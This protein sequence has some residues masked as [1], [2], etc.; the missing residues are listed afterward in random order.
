MKYIYLI[1]LATILLGCSGMED[2][3]YKLQR[4]RNQKGE[5][6]YRSNQHHLATNPVPI[7]RIRGRYPWEK[8]LVGAHPKITKEFFRCKGNGLNASRIITEAGKEPVRLSDC[9]GIDKHSLY[10]RGGDEFIYPILLDLLNYVQARTGKR[11][12]ITSGYRCPEHNAYVDSSIRSR[13]SKH[14]IGAEVDFYV[15]GLESRPEVIIKLLQ[16]YYLEMPKYKGQK[17]FECFDRYDK[18]E[19][20]VSTLPWYNKEIFIKLYK[21]SE[22]RDFDNRHAY[23]YINIQVRYDF[24]RK[25][26]VVYNW[27]DAFHNYHRK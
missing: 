17:S 2:S 22:G 21:P 14:M 15:Q 10:L 7:Q 18:K 25:E 1:M 13:T 12:V 11:V 26:S 8:N 23:S 4:D 9:G 6:I 5:Y 3:E 27:N 16:Q 19:C 20:Y 24:D